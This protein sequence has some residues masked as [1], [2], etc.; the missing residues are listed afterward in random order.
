[1]K[2]LICMNEICARINLTE[3][4]LKL[5]V[6][7]SSRV[8]GHVVLV[9]LCNEPPTHDC[10]RRERARLPSCDSYILT[11]KERAMRIKL[12]T[13]KQQY[14]CVNMYSSSFSLRFEIVRGCV[15]AT[16]F[17]L[18]QAR[19]RAGKTA[20]KTNSQLY[21]FAVSMYKVE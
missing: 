3:F 16:T 1:M 20:V 12:L 9:N 13:T 18:L 15:L 7:F 10:L 4:T 11:A 14:K 19:K 21:H 8:V 2:Y 17:S 6:N 5:N